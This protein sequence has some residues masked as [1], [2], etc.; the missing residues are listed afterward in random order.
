[1]STGKK[2]SLYIHIP[3]CLSKC[4]YCD[5]F[6]VVNRNVDFGVSE[7]QGTD[8]GGSDCTR[9]DCGSTDCIKRV[10]DLYVDALCNEIVYRIK[11]YE[12]DSLRS[13]YVGGGTPSLLDEKQI[14]KICDTIFLCRDA[15]CKKSSD[16]EDGKSI[17]ECE[18][19]FCGDEK[20]D[21]EFTIEVNPD[22]VTKE[23]LE[24]LEKNGVNRISCGIQSCTD[25]CLKFVNRRAGKNENLR[26]MELISRCW[27]GKKSFDLICGLPYE[28]EKS[29]RESLD[30]VMS[31]NPDHI[32]MYSLTIENETVLGRKCNSG[33]LDYDFNFADELWLSSKTY[34]EK[35]NYC[36]YEVS[37]FCKP[38]F[39]CI[40]NLVYWNH[41][42]YLG[43]G[44]G[45]TG[46]VYDSDG[47]GYRWTNTTDI[48]KYIEFWTEN[49]GRDLNNTK[50]VDGNVGQQNCDVQ[51]FEK[52]ILS[53]CKVEAIDLEDSVFEYFMMGL[54]KA[55]GITEKDFYNKFKKPMPDEIIKLFEK[56]QKKGHAEI[57]TEENGRRFF[58]TKEGLLFLNRF[59]EEI[60]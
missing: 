14:K 15:F 37:N 34:L 44:S 18:K 40:H 7:R 53:V 13:V 21:F 56:W 3:F 50:Y 26:A 6:S 35:N 19:T 4:E 29:F 52:Q 22:D 1:M 11:K 9:E 57:I 28:T 42:D 2:L 45:A 5:F 33:L 55:S 30:T 38:G 24:C 54:R 27:K 32:S 16:F 59:L 49:A 41:K 23:L 8:F 12:P 25:A 17:Y 10:P 58:L 48:K 31:F 36:Q 47:R 60:N 51:D 43:C 20:S 39:E 46:T